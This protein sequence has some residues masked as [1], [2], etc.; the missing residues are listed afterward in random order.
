MT[1]KK[2][3]AR[4][5]LTRKENEPPLGAERKEQ[6]GTLFSKYESI[7]IFIRKRKKI[8]GSK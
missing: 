7:N 8:W 2:M 4:P 3:R 1:F 6:N 5:K